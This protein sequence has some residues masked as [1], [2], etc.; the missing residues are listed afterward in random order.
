M[1]YDTLL[2]SF[3]SQLNTRQDKMQCRFIPVG[4][5]PPCCIYHV[6]NRTDKYYMWYI[7]EY[8]HATK[9]TIRLLMVQAYTLE[10]N[11]RISKM[12]LILILYTSRSRDAQIWQCSN[13]VIIVNDQLYFHILYGGSI[14]YCAWV[15]KHKSKWSLSEL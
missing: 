7:I 1:R 8:C 2:E 3:S 15:V 12:K 4:D 9:H 14:C 5:I 10:T 6:S 13:N 11:E